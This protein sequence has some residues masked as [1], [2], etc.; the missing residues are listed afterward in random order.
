MSVIG[1]LGDGV[2]SN[3]FT[4]DAI[5][6]DHYHRRRKWEVT[7]EAP[8]IK[9]IS[10]S[11]PSAAEAMCDSA[12]TFP[13][14]KA[15]ALVQ[16]FRAEVLIGQEAKHFAKSDITPTPKPDVIQRLY[17]RVLQLVFRI[18]P[19]SLYLAPLSEN[20]QHPSLYEGAAPIMNLFLRM[21]Q[22]LPMCHVYDFS[23]SDL[24]TP[25]AKQTITVMSGIMNFL[26]FRKQRMEVT[27]AHQQ[28]FRENMDRQKACTQGIKDAERR[29]KELTTIPPEQ[30]AEAKEL[31]KAL[32]ELHENTAQAYQEV[33]NLKAEVSD[34]KNENNERM[35]KLSQ[36]KTDVSAL[37]EAISK[38]KSQIVESPEDLKN[39]MMK[40]KE[41]IKTIKNSKELADEKLV[42]W[43]ISVQAVE[44][45][46][47]EIQLLYKL[48]QD[49]Q[50]SMTKAHHQQEEIQ[51]LASEYEQHLKELKAVGVEEAQLKRAHAMKQDKESKQ[52]IR[53]QKK[54][55]MKDHHLRNIMGEYDR[56]HQKREEV[57]EEIQELRRETQKLKANMQNMKDTCNKEI[58][59]AQTLYDH[60]L[61]NLDQFHKRIEN[62]IVEGSA[63]IHKIKSNF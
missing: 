40:M 48:L 24:L 1:S 16:F 36:L 56:V 27:A 41:N 33:N 44:Q 17:M 63:D 20:I 39:E 35:Q 45:R 9:I 49:L 4:V 61:S 29:I 3:H 8:K 30:Q 5:P 14:Y 2:S 34:G 18:K 11:G 26:H 22:F 60:L 15:D 42:E 19:E 43:Q 55:E 62:H 31:D 47:V 53:R 6:L 57:V 13:V 50:T 10:S 59:K 46:K 32:A 38:L 12:N 23:L 52:Q 21:R 54:K 28:S 7:T 25:R 37:K 58:Q 51:Q